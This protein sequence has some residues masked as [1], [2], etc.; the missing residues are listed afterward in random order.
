[1]YI[2]LHIYQYIFLTY[3]KSGNFIQYKNRWIWFSTYNI[4]CFP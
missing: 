4:I 1:M 3:S 2:M